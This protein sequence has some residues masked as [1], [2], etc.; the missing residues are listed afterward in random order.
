MLLIRRLQTV[1]R[2]TASAPGRI[3]RGKHCRRISSASDVGIMHGTKDHFPV[4]PGEADIR[5]ALG[6]IVAGSSLKKS[7]Q[8]A[9]F[10]TFVVDETL[11]GR[12]N[13]I[14][15]Y[16][17]AADALG[18]DDSFDPQSDPIVRVEAGRLRRA[19]Q[20]YYANGGSDDPIV[21]DLPRGCYVPAFRSGK[22]RRGAVARLSELRRQLADTLRDNRWLVMVTAAIAVMVSL[23]LNLIW[24][25]VD[26]LV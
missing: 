5:A 20:H 4:H 7:P 23:A 18:R 12:A 15:A 1:Q 2:F 10:L 13:R 25:L 14:K 11:A 19:L 21:I 8:L 9:N 3:Y 24:R 16:N 26:A 22:P 6:R 17:I